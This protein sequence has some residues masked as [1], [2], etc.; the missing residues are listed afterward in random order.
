M[1]NTDKQ[2]SDD[3]VKSDEDV[4][5]ELEAEAAPADD[6]ADDDETFR[7]VDDDPEQ[8]VQGGDEADDD[9][10]EADIPDNA[11][12]KPE[13]D[14][15]DD[16]GSDDLDPVT[17]KEQNDRLEKQFRSEQNRAVGQQRRADRLAKRVAELE[18]KVNGKKD[19]TP[20]NAED[21]EAIKKV[22][23]EYPDVAG[24]L[25]KRMEDLQAKLESTS[26]DDAANL[27]EAQAELDD[28]E[29][30]QLDKFHAEHADGFDVISENA[31][32]FGEW[33][34]DQPKQYRDIFERNRKVMT[35]GLGAALLVSRFKNDL[36]NAGQETEVDERESETSQRLT[37]RRQRQLDGARTTTRG[38]RTTKIVT[39][40]P[41]GDL[42]EEEA[43]KYWDRVEARKKNA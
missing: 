21:D 25:V 38:K 22:A 9:E 35:D 20:R 41:T 29:R 15:G 33:I 4:W 43:W 27:E 17:L 24:P 5:N 31:V 6:D 40:E 10:D 26:P 14:G 19:D 39:D 23:E 30:E 11:D 37:T 42:S 16:E 36:L 2:K 32:L 8:I 34:E 1:T 13:A 28:L 18:A 12:D 3:V 7:Q